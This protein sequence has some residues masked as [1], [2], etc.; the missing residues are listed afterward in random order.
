VTTFYLA[1][2]F[3]S[4]FYD[5]S[6]FSS[7][8][9]TVM[10]NGS[11]NTVT[12]QSFSLW[13]GT[14]LDLQVN[15]TDANSKPLDI[16]NSTIEWIAKCINS[17]SSSIIKKSLNIVNGLSGSFTISLVPSDTKTILNQ[18]YQHACQLMDANGNMTIL[19]VGQITILQT[20]NGF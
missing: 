13:S 6:A 16:S 2:S 19:F 17:N 8:I 18:L 4:I 10:L 5:E 3:P 7:I 11:I 15:V 12:S 20:P 1:P 9:R 14:S